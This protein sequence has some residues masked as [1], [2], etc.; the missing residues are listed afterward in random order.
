[1]CEY[2]YNNQ[3]ITLE[4]LLKIENTV[5]VLSERQEKSYDECLLSFYRT[6]TFKAL[7]NPQTCMWSE[8]ADFIADEY[9]REKSA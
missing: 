8:T 7:K 9:F 3:N 6:D 2:R 4:I 5:R 1:M